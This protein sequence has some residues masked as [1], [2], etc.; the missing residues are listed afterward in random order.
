MEAFAGNE[1]PIIFNDDQRGILNIMRIENLL[2]TVRPEV[3]EPI[4]KR[5]VS[6]NYIQNRPLHSLKNGLHQSI[7]YLFDQ[8]LPA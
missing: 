7:S 4:Y 8:Q 1:L 3:E 2:E 5:D 6:P